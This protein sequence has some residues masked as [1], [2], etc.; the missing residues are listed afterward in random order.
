MLKLFLM[1]IMMISMIF[2]LSSL[3]IML[4]LLV[5]FLAVFITMMKGGIWDVYLVLGSDLMSMNLV[6]LS[7]WITFLMLFASFKM[8]LYDNNF[9]LFYSLFMLCMLML[10]FYSMNLL[11]FYVFFE[12]VLFPIIMLIFNWGNQPER[13]QAGIYMLMYTLFGSLPLLVIMIMNGDN[14]LMY[15]YMIWDEKSIGMLFYLMMLGFLVKIPMFLLHLWLPKAHVEAPIAGSMILAAVLL[16]LGV[17]GIYRFKMFFMME[18]LSMGYLIMVISCL[19]GMMVGFICMFQTDIKSLIAYSSICHMGIVL[20]GMMNMNFWGSFGSLLLMIGHGLCSSGLF[21]LG[22]MMYERFYTRSIM[23]L[24]GL[25][26]IFPNLSL[27]WFFLSVV[28]MSAPPSMN[29]FGEI[30]LFGSLL[31]FSIFFIY[32]LMMISFISACYSLYMYSYINHGDGWSLWSVS[33]ISM[34]EYLLMFFHFSPLLIWVLKMECFFWW[35]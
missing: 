33:M 6:L 15:L 8:N 18:M 4:L 19:G 12:S 10:C 34:R 29:L 17:Y 13:L 24:K 28:N 11:G 27:W 31:K 14:T 23:L 35:L 1:M 20:G 25:G 5:L 7:V 22:N 21:C 30:F 32:P 9:F 26:K 3:E 16:K 2:V